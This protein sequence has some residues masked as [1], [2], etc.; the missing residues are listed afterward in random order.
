VQPPDVNL[1][2]ETI[3]SSL[4]TQPVK[5]SQLLLRPQI[6]FQAIIENSAAVKKEIERLQMTEEEIENV[7]ISVKY[8]PYIIKEKELADK[9]SKIDNVKIPSN[10]DYSSFVSLSL[11]AREKLTK[12]KPQN[13]GQASRISGVSPA[14]VAILLMHLT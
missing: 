6:S 7:E 9:M 12:V 4:L 14:D 1:H 11:E 8:G 10:I 3:G 2:L 13:L 5:I